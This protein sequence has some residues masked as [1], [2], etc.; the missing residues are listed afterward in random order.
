MVLG[1]LRMKNSN[2]INEII[3]QKKSKKRLGRQPTRSPSI[4]PT[5]EPY[6]YTFNDSID[7][8]PSGSSTASRSYG[9]SKGKQRSM[10]SEMNE[11]LVINWTTSSE[12]VA[13]RLL[14]LQNHREFKFKLK[15]AL[16]DEEEVRFERLLDEDQYLPKRWKSN[17]FGRH[18]TN[19]L[20][21]ATLARMEGEDYD[22]YVRKRM[23]SRTH[24]REY[25]NLKEKEEREREEGLKRKEKRREE[26]RRTQER[27]RTQDEKEIRKK[28]K[29]LKRER[30]RYETKWKMINSLST[31]KTSQH[32]HLTSKSTLEF[33]QI[34]WPIFT[35]EEEIKDSTEFKLNFIN[36]FTIES[37]QTFLF[38]EIIDL[39][40]KKKIIKSTLLLYHPDRF[41]SLILERI[42]VD[43]IQKG[44]IQEI[45]LRVSQILNQINQ[46]L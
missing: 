44:W 11:E 17:Q 39:N 42:H 12:E 37:I 40:L 28:E 24:K 30:E 23:W 10:G 1:K 20:N 16:G 29:R 32:D 9:E 41:H 7:L 45:G 46:A 18:Q 14:S 34:P 15:D 35:T 31:S 19:D 33:H 8:H 21:R 3:N 22:E 2:E 5:P 26:K 27:I 25:L 38:K 43:Q 4:D 6:G 36:R 13:N